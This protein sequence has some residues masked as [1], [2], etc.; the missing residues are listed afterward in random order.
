MVDERRDEVVALAARTERANQP[1]HLLVIAGVLVLASVVYLVAGWRA[2]GAAAAELAGEISNAGR[3]QEA[4]GSLRAL[5]A[6]GNT[7]G[8]KASESSNSILSRIQQAGADAGL[9][10]AIGV[11]KSGSGRPAVTNSN[12]DVAKVTWA[13]TVRDP[14]LGALLEFTKRATEGVS[15]LEIYAVAI[16]PQAGE[17]EMTVE[18]C[19]WER[20]EGS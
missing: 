20:V 3:V 6:A 1:R 13:Y 17:W 15:G 19:R 9:K 14:S 16:K 5:Q 18:F 11:P 7:S 2:Q 8:P 12:K 10:N 4:L